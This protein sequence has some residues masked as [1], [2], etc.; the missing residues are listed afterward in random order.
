M[1]HNSFAKTIDGMNQ[2]IKELEE[3][4]KS[5]RMITIV[6]ISSGYVLYYKL[7]EKENERQRTNE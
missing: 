5:F 2:V 6:P 3:I 4:Y 1:I 7:M